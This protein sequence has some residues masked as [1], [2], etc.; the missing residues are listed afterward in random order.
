MESQKTLNAG[1]ENLSPCGSGRRSTSNHSS[2]PEFEF[3]MVRNWPFPEPD[4]IS[5]D[6][7]FV[8]GV[9][10]PLHLLPNKQPE[11]NP[12]IGSNQSASQ[13]HIPDPDPEPD[14]IITSDPVP[15]LSASKRWRDIFK[16][17]KGKN[18]KQSKKDKDK[19]KEK[20]NHSPS[21]SGASGAELNINI[22]PFS[23]SRSAGTR[24]RMTARSTGTRKVSSAPCSRSNSAGEFKSRK[25]PS[26]PGRARV[27][28][29]R[30]SPVWQVRRGSSPAKTVDVTGRSAEKSSVTKE[31]TETR[32]GKICTSGNNANKAKVLNLH[33]PMC[34][35]YRHHLNCRTDENSAMLA[36]I[37]TGSDDGGNVRSGDATVGSGSNFFNLRNLFTKKV[38]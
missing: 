38:Y 33:V 13:P 23:R 17:E 15:V 31:V 22:W 8:N 37:S 36:G 20:K 7:L 24:P 12:Q 19:E 1:L 25:W 32:G 28:L 14:P 18:G 11:E 10:R 9:L 4:L 2:S 29:V 3:W 5:A 6:E 35:G 26:S 16:K 34:I 27:H 21:Q 30:R